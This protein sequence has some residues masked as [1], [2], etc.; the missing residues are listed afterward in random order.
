[1]ARYFV[2][3]PFAHTIF[4]LPREDPGLAEAVRYPEF[5][6]YLSQGPDVLR[7]ED[8]KQNTMRRQFMS[9]QIIWL[10]YLRAV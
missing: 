9:G 2:D 6:V 10:Q 4:S 1:M 3:Y 7:T 8:I 5:I